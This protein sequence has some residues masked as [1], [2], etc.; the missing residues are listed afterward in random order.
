MH[1]PS[2]T[3]RMDAKFVRD[4]TVPDGT[5]VQPGTKLVKRWVM[6]NTGTHAWSSN[7]KVSMCAR[8]NTG[9]GHRKPESS[10]KFKFLS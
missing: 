7:T 8:R 1:F 9:S 6:K 2:V 5:H 3:R 10:R 4:D